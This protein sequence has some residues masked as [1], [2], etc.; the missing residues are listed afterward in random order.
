MDELMF[1]NSLLK[2]THATLDYL[3]QINRFTE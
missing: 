1:E 2:Y 3:E